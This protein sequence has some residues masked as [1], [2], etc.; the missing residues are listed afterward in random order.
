MLRIGWV[1]W[2]QGEKLGRGK[3]MGF[4]TVRC[5]M[6][7]LVG[8]NVVAVSEM[9]KVSAKACGLPRYSPEAR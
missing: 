1:Y 8:V 3:D 9:S 6:H 7:E 5:R 4:G 2:Q